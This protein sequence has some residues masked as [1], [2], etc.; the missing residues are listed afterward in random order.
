MCLNGFW[1]GHLEGRA[2]SHRIREILQQ[3][4]NYAPYDAKIRANF[5]VVTARQAKS[6]P[7]FQKQCADIKDTLNEMDAMEKRKR[8]MLAELRAQF[9]DD[10]KLQ[11]TFD[12]LHQLEDWSDKTEPIW[13]ELIACANR[14]ESASK[15]EQSNYSSICIEP[16]NL[17]LELLRPESERLIAQL[18]DDLKTNLGELPP[19][20]LQVFGQ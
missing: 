16:A 11:P 14:L 7:E 19:E 6:F 15:Y 4:R 9:G 5:Q 20:F 13:Q 17:Q 8:S 2:R 10:K 1:S 3:A 12:T 18:K